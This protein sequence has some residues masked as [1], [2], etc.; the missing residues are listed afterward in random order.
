MSLYLIPQL[1]H[2]FDL[3]PSHPSTASRCARLP[4]WWYDIWRSALARALA[5]DH[6]GVL[7]ASP[8]AR[9]HVLLLVLFASSAHSGTQIGRG[10]FAHFT[11]GQL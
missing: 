6:Q 8:G 7:R 5:H 1:V 3:I 11:L 9:D 10:F 2:F 4:G